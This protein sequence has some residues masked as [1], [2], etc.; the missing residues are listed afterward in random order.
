M[1][2]MQNDLNQL[3]GLPTQKKTVILLLIGFLFIASVVVGSL[4]S[5]NKADKTATTTQEQ[6]GTDTQTAPSTT[7]TLSP[8][9]TTLK[10]GQSTTMTVDLASVP[11]AATDI[12]IAF[13][14]EIFTVSDVKNGNVFARVIRNKVEEGKLV[15]SASVDPNDAENLKEGKVLTFKLTAKK[16][17]DS[18]LLQFV[19]GDTIT[20][21]NGDNTLGVTNGAIVKVAK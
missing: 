1:N 5:R 10:V 20:A 15:F 16:Q 11:V 2:T 17:A 19:Q 14:Q 8:A 6:A 3:K 13:D 18:A 7:L 4:M 9:E 21:L 12:V